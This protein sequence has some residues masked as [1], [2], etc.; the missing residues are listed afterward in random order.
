MSSMKEFA[1]L[2]KEVQEQQK[3]AKA[4][5]KFSK[6]LKETQLSIVVPA[7]ELKEDIVINEHIVIEE[8]IATVEETAVVEN[9]ETLVEDTIE[10]ISP[11]EKVA[12]SINSK[13]INENIES[14]RWNDPLRRDP[15]EKFVTFKELND[16][17]TGFLGRIQ[18]QL[19]SLGGGGEVNF[20]YLDDVNR[21]TMTGSNN[22]HVLEYDA[23]TGKVQF[24]SD[25]GP[26]Q[27]LWFDPNH[28]DER[29]DVGLL[30]WNM[31]DDTLNLHHPN[32][33]TQQIGQEL[34]AYVRNRTGAT[35]PDGTAVQFA[36]AEQNGTARLLIAPFLANGTFPNLYG[37]GITTSD[38]P[39]G[40]D[41]FVTVWGKVKR[42]NTSAWNVGDILYVSPTIAGGLTNIKPTAP[43]NVVPIAAVLRKDSTQGE[44]FVRPTIEQ[45]S[46]YGSFSDNQNHTAALANT[47]YP[48]PLNITEFSNA[49]IRDPNDTT[50][51][52]IQQSGLYN[53]QFSTQFVSTN[54]SA[55]DVY[56]WPRKNG[57]DIPN[58]A[59][60]TSVVGNGVYFVASWNFVIS[61]D[62]NDYFQ[63]MW[64][65]TDTAASIVAPLSTSFAPAT[66]STLLS[67]TMVAQ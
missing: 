54:S 59:T 9:T 27:T 23:A 21:A 63:L 47:P 45:R 28:V 42:L 25:I 20:R 13:K 56:I 24:T 14:E 19:S 1:K 4:L 8:P 48:I 12:M 43:N 26:I 36:G 2:L 38:I 60:R 32:G 52:V 61:M 64:A 67:V 58:S 7:E 35:I 44:I 30:N 16:H 29:D 37:L 17:Y 46:P 3:E 11:I 41:G 57:I 10:E 6:L 40:E 53:F 55:K 18:Q 5:D 51:I 31:A 22:N 65:T 50:K 39:N 34:Y 66:P 62:N 15:T 33:V 49:I